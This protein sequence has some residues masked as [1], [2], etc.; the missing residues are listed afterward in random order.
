M[1]YLHRR[2]L[3]A[4]HVADFRSRK[5]YAATFPTPLPDDAYCDNWIAGNALEL[6]RRFP[7][8]KPWHLAVNFN[9]PHEPMDITAAMEKRWRGVS[10]PQPNRNTEFPPETHVAIRQNYTAMVE[11]IDRNVGIFLEEVR[12]R[13]ELDNTIVVFS[14]DHGEMLGD[15]DR[16]AKSVPFQ[17]SVGVPL[18]IAGPGVR[19]G[20]SDALVSI[21][22]L[23]AT[24]LDYAGLTVPRDMD[25]RSLR[26]LAEGATKTHREYVRSGLGRWRMVWDGRYKLITGLDSGKKAKR[27]KTEPA[28]APREPEPIL[29]DL[30][31]DP[32][33]N[34]N[35][36]TSG[37]QHV[38]RLMPLLSKSRI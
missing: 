10:F 16:W 8:G 33:E 30:E 31:R 7:A 4:V 21:V 27:A 11:N 6:M 37:G 3:A 14:S 2:N 19:Q 12:K 38:K 25:S 32:L 15:H 9:G 22:D 29:Y 5:G 36:A 17:P 20:T 1:A 34:D 18:V 24:F 23:S 13:G 28:D 35:I 26:P